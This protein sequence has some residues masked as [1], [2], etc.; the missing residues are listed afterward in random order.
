MTPSKMRTLWDNGSFNEAEGS[1]WSKVE[2]TE[3]NE[4]VICLPTAYMEAVLPS[5]GRGDSR[6]KPQ[7]EGVRD[8]QFA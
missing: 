1:E 3:S 2:W 6:E 5:L 7:H 8:G 4:A